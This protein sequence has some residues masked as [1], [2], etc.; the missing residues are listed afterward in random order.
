[1][2][3]LPVVFRMYRGEVCAYFPTE[4]SDDAGIL[5]TCYA[6]IGQH[7]AACRSWLTKGRPATPEEYKDL[8]AELR[9]IYEHSSGDDDPPIALK[10]Y[11]RAPRRS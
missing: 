7:G 11:K 8:L 2:E 9:S 4:K 5:I 3:T 10:V 6:H 1:M